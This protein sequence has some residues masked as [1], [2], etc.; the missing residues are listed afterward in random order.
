MLSKGLDSGDILFH[1]VPELQDSDS[2]FDFTMRSV[3][4]AQRELAQ[5]LKNGQIFSISRVQQDKNLEIRYSKNDEFTDD[6]AKEFLEKSIDLFSEKFE[7][8]NLLRPNFK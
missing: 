5:I 3:F 2:H 8:P 7:Y 1:C 4:A 6:V